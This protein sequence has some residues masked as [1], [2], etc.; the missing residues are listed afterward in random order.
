[1]PSLFAAD[2]QIFELVDVAAVD[3]AAQLVLAIGDFDR[4]AAG[5]LEDVLNGRRRPACSEMPAFASSGGKILTWYCFSRPPTDATSATPGTALQ[6]RLDL[7][8]VQQPQLAHVVRAFVV[9]DRVLI[10]PAHAAGV[11]PKRHRRHPPAVAAGSH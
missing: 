1:M 3:R 8:F 5:F 4:A 9:H 2:H 7:A 10:D 6:R 11:G